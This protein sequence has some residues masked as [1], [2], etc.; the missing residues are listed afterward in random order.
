M[1]KLLVTS[2]W[3]EGAKKS[4]E[5]INLDENSSNVTCDDLPTLWRGVRGA[6]GKLFARRTPIICGGEGNECKCQAFENGIWNFIPDPSECRA[7]ASSALL[8]ASDKNEVL[9]IA[10]GRNTLS[11]KHR[12]SFF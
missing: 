5:I 10:G 6:T 4:V 1:T 3:A 11:T 7:S 8:T 9:F 12:F 2:G